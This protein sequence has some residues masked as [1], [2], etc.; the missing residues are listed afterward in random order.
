MTDHFPFSNKQRDCGFS[1][2]G[3]SKEDNHLILHY[4]QSNSV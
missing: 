3:K 4:L 1:R 2:G